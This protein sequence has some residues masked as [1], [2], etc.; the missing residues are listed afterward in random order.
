[1]VHE[2]LFLFSF[3]RNSSLL[4]PREFYDFKTLSENIG[5]WKNGKAL[6]KLWLVRKTNKLVKK[7]S[8]QFFQSSEGYPI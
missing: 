1:M 5:V 6:R 2:W 7:A 8:D 3:F 4:F